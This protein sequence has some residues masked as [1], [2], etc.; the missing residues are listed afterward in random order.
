[1]P[2][3]VYVYV[4]NSGSGTISVINPHLNKVIETISLTNVGACYGECNPYYLAYDPSNYEIYVQ[5]FSA[6]SSDTV[7]LVINTTTNSLNA[8]L[9]LAY[10]S[11]IA[12]LRQGIAYDP[13]N[14]E[15]YVFVQGSC[16]FGMDGRVDVVDTVTNTIVDITNVGTC[17]DVDAPVAYD[18]ANQ[19]VYVGSGYFASIA[20]GNVSAISSSTNRVVSV[21]SLGNDGNDTNGLAYDPLSQEMYVTSVASFAPSYSAQGFLCQIDS[22]NSILGCQYLNPFGVNYPG[23]VAFDPADGAMYVGN[24]TVNYP[25]GNPGPVLVFGA[26]YANYISS[27]TAFGAV[28]SFAYSSAN[29]GEL[30]VPNQLS[31]TVTELGAKSYVPFSPGEVFL[32]LGSL[33]FVTYDPL[34]KLLYASQEFASYV[35]AYNPD[36]DSLVHT[37]SGFNGALGLAYS[38]Q[39]QTLMVANDFNG[40]VS[41]VN[42]TSGAYMGSLPTGRGPFDVVYDPIDQFFYVS[43]NPSGNVSLIQYNYTDRIWITESLNRIFGISPNGFNYPTGIAV[44]DNVTEGISRVY[45]ANSGNGTISDLN[46]NNGQ[47]TDIPVGNLPWLLTAVNNH[48]YVP[49]DLSG[50]ISVINIP[51]DS[52]VKTINGVP[53]AYQAVYDPQDGDVFVSEFYKSGNVVAIDGGGNIVAQITGAQFGNFYQNPN[54][55]TYDTADGQMYVIA[56]NLFGIHS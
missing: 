34:H 21:M 1:M 36:T 2:K 28:T 25:N 6:Y 5:A 48:V 3:M 56:V 13:A 15:V 23:G 9:I 41:L 50:Q 26:V 54:F 17:A 35:F 44:Y 18:P 33:S 42:T 39:L 31:S 55:M 20:P 51:T 7:L 22:T 32:G 38:P 47:V 4:A 49:D 40:T 14:Q 16:S 12:P 10:N 45:V 19:Q 37:Y 11:A 27:I 24:F 29:G 53:E 30:F 52:V 46:F 8:S 43:N